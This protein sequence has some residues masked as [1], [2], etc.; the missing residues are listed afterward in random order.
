MATHNDYQ[1]ALSRK[2]HLARTAYP[3]MLPYQWDMVS[4]EK[5]T[6]FYFCKNTCRRPVACP[7]ER[8]NKTKGLKIAEFIFSFVKKSLFI[9]SIYSVA[10]G[11]VFKVHICRECVL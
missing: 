1:M 2:K 8:G 10:F 4:S 3:K 9:H 11:V 5:F 7:E 6:F